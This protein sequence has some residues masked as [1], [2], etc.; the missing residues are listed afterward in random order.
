V[1]ELLASPFVLIGTIDEIIHQL[2]AAHRDW[3]ISRYTVREPAADAI[4]E[5]IS[6]LAEG[7]P[8]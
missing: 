2:G 8:S 3:G 4:T 6:K 1:A 5:V 7:R